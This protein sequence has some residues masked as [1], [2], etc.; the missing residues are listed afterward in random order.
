MNTLSFALI[1]NDGRNGGGAGD[2]IIQVMVKGHKIFE[3]D[4]YNIYCDVPITVAEATLGAEIQ[5]PTLDGKVSFTIPEGTQSGTTFCVRGKGIQQL[6]GRGRGDLL[7]TVEIEVPKGLGKKQK[8]A[9]EKF[10]ELCEE[11][12]HGKKASFF[13]KLKK[14]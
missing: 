10:G 9:L 11:K 7:V 3:R 2:L 6:N 4:G 14:K 13:A 12:H 5:V 1:G 8:E